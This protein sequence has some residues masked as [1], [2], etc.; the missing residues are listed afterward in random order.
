MIKEMRSD[1][2]PN[3]ILHFNPTYMQK[4]LL[5]F[6]GAINVMDNP[7]FRDVTFKVMSRT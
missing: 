2:K 5:F 3:D 4:Q 1:Q 7:E 6:C